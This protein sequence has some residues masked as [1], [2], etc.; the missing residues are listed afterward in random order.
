MQATDDESSGG[1]RWFRA[2]VLEEGP[3]GEARERERESISGRGNVQHG[4]S[5][6][7]LHEHSRGRVLGSVH[8]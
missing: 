3:K 8:F 2:K 4:G 5:G 6:V 1:E 7:R